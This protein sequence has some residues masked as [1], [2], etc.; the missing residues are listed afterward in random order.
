[1]GF[2]GQS[3]VVYSVDGAGPPHSISGLGP[4]DRIIGW[5]SD[6]KS[7]YLNSWEGYSTKISRFDLATGR[8]EVLK[9]IT[10]N[11]PSGVFETPT[12]IL[13]PDGKGYIYTTRRFLTDLY[14]A[15]GLK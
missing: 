14:L 8:Q 7:L 5:S 9:E 13:T 12:L 10:L 11:D 6:G 2:D 3:D 15:E 4:R 1:M